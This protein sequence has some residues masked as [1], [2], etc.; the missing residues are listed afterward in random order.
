MGARQ[1]GYLRVSSGSPIGDSEW[2]LNLSAELSWPALEL[3]FGLGMG[4]GERHA[5]SHLSVMTASEFKS[6][7][8]GFNV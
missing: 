2:C 1:K 5:L 6:D 3:I 8:H 7:G 4:S